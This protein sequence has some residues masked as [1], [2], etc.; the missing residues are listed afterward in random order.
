MNLIVKKIILA[1]LAITT[2][3]AAFSQVS[4]ATEPTTALAATLQSNTTFVDSVYRESNGTFKSSFTAAG[5]DWNKVNNFTAFNL[6]TPLSATLIDVNYTERIPYDVGIKYGSTTSL[7]WTDLNN[8]RSFS[9]QTVT[10]SSTLINTNVSFFSLFQD[11]TKTYQNDREGW[12][13]YNVT[14]TNTYLGFAEVGLRTGVDYNDS[15]ILFQAAVP[16]PETYAMLLGVMTIGLVTIR[17]YRYG[18]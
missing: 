13:F 6:N 1:L 14:G 9:T 4:L 11:T 17:R 18:R 8:S 3:T 12:A 10:L 5:L 16:E 7:L 15:V 2:A